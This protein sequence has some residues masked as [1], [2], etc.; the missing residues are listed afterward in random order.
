[1]TNGG[2]LETEIEKHANAWDIGGSAI[3]RACAIYRDWGHERIISLHY[4]SCF[5]LLEQSRD[6]TT[7]HWPQCSILRISK[8]NS[9]PISH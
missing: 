3:S 5:D 6:Y 8:S 2:A 4:L 1:M 7:V 9:N